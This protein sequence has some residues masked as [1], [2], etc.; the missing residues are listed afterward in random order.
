MKTIAAKEGNI[1]PVQSQKLA[2]SPPKKAEEHDPVYLKIRD[3]VYRASGIYHSE[4]KL[5]LLVAACN[6]RIAKG[7]T[8]R[9]PPMH[10]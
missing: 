3:I 10:G 2:P 6:R 9:T 7:Q 1:V 5:Y 8:H 4:E